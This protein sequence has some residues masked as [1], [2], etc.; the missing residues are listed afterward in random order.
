MRSSAAKI[1]EAEYDALRA[2]FMAGEHLTEDEIARARHH[3]DAKLC[4]DIQEYCW[5]EKLDPHR[6]IRF[7]LT[8]LL[9]HI[10]EDMIRAASRR[11]D[12]EARLARL[13]AAQPAQRSKPRITVKAEGV[14]A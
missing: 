3:S 14:P 1:T 6:T 7:V 11:Q 5:K 10:S 2:R 9:R 12:L 4:R 13:E 8:A